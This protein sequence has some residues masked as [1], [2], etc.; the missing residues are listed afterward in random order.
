[1]KFLINTLIR[2]P[3]QELNYLKYYFSNESF[4]FFLRNMKGV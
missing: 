1:M 2:L 3:N 4:L